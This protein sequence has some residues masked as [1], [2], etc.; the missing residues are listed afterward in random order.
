MWYTKEQLENKTLSEL[1]RIYI[2][3]DKL[4]TEKNQ[5]EYL[6]LVE[7]VILNNFTEKPRVKLQRVYLEL[8]GTDLPQKSKK[9][10]KQVKHCAVDISEHLGLWD[11]NSISDL[12]K[13]VAER[14]SIA[15]DNL[16]SVSEI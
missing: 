15:E 1:L 9:H 16:K 11:I 13:L 5:L 6:R 12:K 8:D 4:A 7:G 3:A 10:L 14:I 2:Q